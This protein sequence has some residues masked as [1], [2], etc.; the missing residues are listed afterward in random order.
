VSSWSSRV[1]NL[2]MKNCFD[3]GAQLEVVWLGEPK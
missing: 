3:K 1:K 2:G